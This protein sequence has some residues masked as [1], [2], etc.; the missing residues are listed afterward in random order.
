[1]ERG[2]TTA[3]RTAAGRSRLS[4]LQSPL[5]ALSIFADWPAHKLAAVEQL[6]AWRR[7][8]A[9]ETIL[10]HLEANDDVFFLVDGKARASIYSVGGKSVTFCDL[11]G[12]EMFG[13]YA[14][15][16]GGPRSASIEAMS[17]CYVGSMP[18]TSF[19]ALLR[20]EPTLTLTLLQQ[21]VGKIRTLSTRIYEF[22]TLAVSNRIQAEVL[23]LARLT[24]A[25]DGSAE[26]GPVPT[27]A[28]IAS[29]TSTHREAVTREL[30]RLARA[31]LI[32]R[33]G[34]VL[35]VPDV[36]RLACLVHQ[37]TGE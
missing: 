14:A 32:E 3:R 28:D 2:E 4:A 11:S 31:G 12:G 10:N 34:R 27:H 1:M 9:G 35:R 6:C 29:R 15:I 20:N 26:I 30:N 8:G 16:D 36:E 22:S 37:A 24:E 5:R 23:R 19:R 18:G 21:C 7:Y 17:A 33:R 13:E 25:T